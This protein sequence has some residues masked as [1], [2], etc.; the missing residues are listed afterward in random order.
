[1]DPITAGIVSGGMG[2]FGGMQQNQ[3]SAAEAGNNRA[4]QQHM[5]STSH[6][7]EVNDLRSAGLN[8]VL[9]ALGN[10]APT[11]SGAVAPV[12]NLGEGIS[13]GMDTAVAIRAQNK[14]LDLQ[15]EDINLKRDQAKNLA[16]ER[17]ASIPEIQ[18]KNW[19]VKQEEVKTKILK[20]TADAEIKK[21][22]AS[23][24]YARLNQLMGVINAGTSSAKDVKDLINPINGIIKLKPGKK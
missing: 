3:G 15:D 14:A 17:Q 4:W 23:G 21:A 6:Q 10:G 7:R 2:L 5:A 19:A 13:K 24:D 22:R 11:P 18:A 1:M 20:E 8:P 12:A 16:V 9:S